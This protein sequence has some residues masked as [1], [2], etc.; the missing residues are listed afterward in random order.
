MH[1]YIPALGVLREEDCKFKINLGCT[2]RSF[3][4]QKISFFIIV[5]LKKKKG[6]KSTALM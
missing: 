1:D 3:L 5:Y 2:I 4:N 6:E